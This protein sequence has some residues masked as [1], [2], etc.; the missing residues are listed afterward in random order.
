MK[1]R[2]AAGQ[3]VE[4]LPSQVDSDGILAVRTVESVLLEAWAARTHDLDQTRRLTQRALEQPELTPRDLSMAQRNLGFVDMRHAH[5]ELAGQQ[6]D[7]GAELAR[8]AADSLLEAD[9]LA[10]RAMVYSAFGDYV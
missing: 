10:Y 3:L 9:C 1:T 4:P 2:Y 6:L 8:T 5:Y 7:R